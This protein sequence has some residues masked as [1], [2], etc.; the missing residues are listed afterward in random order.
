MRSA[1]GKQDVQKTLDSQM[2]E[3]GA[4]PSIAMVNIGIG[5]VNPSQSFRIVLHEGEMKGKRRLSIE[6]ER[7]EV[8]LTVRHSTDVTVSSDGQGHTPGSTPASCLICGCPTLLP[9]ADSIA[10]Y[11][12]CQLDWSRALA[13]GQ[14]H[15]SAEGAELWL[16]ERSIES[17]KET[18]R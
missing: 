15:L 16:C 4:E 8:T 3:E 17:F 10:R 13:S 5:T 2:S 6:F 11:S 14:L 12:G 1:V 9:L 18:R 7:R